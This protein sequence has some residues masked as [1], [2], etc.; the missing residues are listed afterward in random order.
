M[1]E[2]ISTAAKATAVGVFLQAAYCDVGCTDIHVTDT[3]LSLPMTPAVHDPCVFNRCVVGAE[4][5]V[6]SSGYRVAGAER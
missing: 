2:S 4:W 6:L 3:F 1:S 5:W